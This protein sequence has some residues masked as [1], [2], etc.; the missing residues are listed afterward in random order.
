MLIFTESEDFYAM[1]RSRSMSRTTW[2]DFVVMETLSHSR[3]A[4]RSRIARVAP[5]SFS[6]GW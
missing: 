2:F 4:M 5:N 1:R 6:A 3:S